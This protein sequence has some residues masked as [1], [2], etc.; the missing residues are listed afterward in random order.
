[1]GKYLDL[2]IHPPAE[3]RQSCQRMAELLSAVHYSTIGLTIPT[4][5]MHDRVKPLQRVFEQ[6]GVSTAPRADFS[7]TSRTELLRVL[8]KFRNLYDI[9]AVKCLNQRVA[10]VACRDRRVDI[11]YFDVAN[12]SLRFTHSFARL[13]RGAIEFNLISDIVERADSWTFS[14]IRKAMGIAR[15]HRVEVVLSSGA[16]SCEMIRSPS[17]ISAL[18][19]ALGLTEEESIRGVS[20][21]PSSIV[22]ENRK[23]RAADY[24]EEGVKIVVPSRR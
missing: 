20:S 6:Y 1:M 17:E 8:R 24:V 11:V 23:K 13:L 4:G 18:A 3:D 15:E 2:H 19:T 22:A 16:R 9:V 7:P 5:L 21:A 12:N 14:R 10:T